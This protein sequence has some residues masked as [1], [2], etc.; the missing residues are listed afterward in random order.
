M[1]EVRDKQAK[2]L[3]QRF[4]FEIVIRQPSPE[5]I[6]ASMHIT[7]QFIT[8]LKSLPRQLENFL[9]WHRPTCWLWR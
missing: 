1:C 2:G 6:Q 3:L 5:A 8:Q 4:P 7:F 9:V